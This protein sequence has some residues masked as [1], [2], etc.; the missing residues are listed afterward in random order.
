MDTKMDEPAVHDGTAQRDEHAGNLEV[1][2]IFGVG[3]D[4]RIFLDVERAVEVGDAAAD[5]GA[6]DEAEAWKGRRIRGMQWF[7]RR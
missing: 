4:P 6:G 1:K 2:S 7:E 3:C 5:Q